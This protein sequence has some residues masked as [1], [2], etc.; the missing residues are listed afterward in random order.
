MKF[1]LICY[2]HLMTSHEPTTTSSI[3]ITFAG[4][5]LPQPAGDRKCF[6]RVHRIPRHGLLCCRK[7]VL[8]VIFHILTNEDVFEPRYNDLK[9]R[10]QN[11]NYFCPNLV[12]CLPSSD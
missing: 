11:C 12:R 6:P 7:T 4:K 3:L 9:F 1:Y 8:T 10:V 5:K 2:I